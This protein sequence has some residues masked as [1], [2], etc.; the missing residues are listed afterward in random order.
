MTEQGFMVAFWLH[1]RKTFTILSNL[2]TSQT[3]T[4]ATLKAQNLGP[5]S[6]CCGT[7]SI[8]CSV[9]EQKQDAK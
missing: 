5:L 9:T 6:A 2:M 7:E 8:D 4:A 3:F 1:L